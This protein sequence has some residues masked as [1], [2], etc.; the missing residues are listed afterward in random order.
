MTRFPFRALS[1][2]AF[3][4]AL[5]ASVTLGTVGCEDKHI[6]RLC[7]VGMGAGGASGT[8]GQFNNQALEC[9]SRICILPPA[10]GTANP[11]TGA[12]CSATCE[13]DDDCS[14][15]E[16]RP[17]MSTDP[18]DKRCRNGFRCRRLL[19]GLSTNP[20]ACK[21]LCVCRDFLPS[22][23]DRGIGNPAGCN[24]DNRE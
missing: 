1:I 2:R 21:R 7:D 12:L 17:N 22:D 5:L 13:S 16:V 10:A 3:G 4:L 24:G 20:L 18:L 14:D 23:D 8:E 19:P 9:P 15:A 11:D 6:G